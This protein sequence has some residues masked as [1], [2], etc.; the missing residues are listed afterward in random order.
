MTAALNDDL[1]LEI[2][3]IVPLVTVNPYTGKRFIKPACVPSTHA[4]HGQAAYVAGWGYDQYSNEGQFN[5]T[6]PDVL[7]AARIN[8]F[9]NE[10]CA[11]FSKY[12]LTDDKE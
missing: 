8:V 4:Y 7:Q 11:N 6:N 3:P 9:S 5:P 1:P 12:K 2:A 10:Y